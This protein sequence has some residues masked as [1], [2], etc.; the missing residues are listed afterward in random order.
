MA[1]KPGVDIEY[2]KKHTDY[3]GFDPSSD[4]IRWFWAAMESF[5]PEDRTMFIRFVW[6]R[7]RLPPPGQ[8]WPQRFTIDRGPVG[9]TQ[10]P[11]AHTCFF[12]IDL[13][14]Y[15]NE[16]TMRDRLLTAIHF[17]VGGILNG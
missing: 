17:G 8:P 12:S 15:S 5:S 13:P 2:L 14:M 1:G 6:G 4:V 9:D 10:L 3:R 7:N 16:R 11:E